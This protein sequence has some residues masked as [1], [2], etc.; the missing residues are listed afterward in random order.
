M[1]RKLQDNLSLLLS[2]RTFWGSKC[3]TKVYS[4]LTL[5]LFTARS[6]LSLTGTEGVWE[7][8]FL[9][10][11]SRYLSDTQV[12]TVLVFQK[13]I[14][15]WGEKKARYPIGLP[16]K[17][18]PL[19]SYT[20]KKW[21]NTYEL[22]WGKQNAL[23]HR[24]N[25][26]LTGKHAWGRQAGR[27]P[28]QRSRTQGQRRERANRQKDGQVLCHSHHRANTV[29]THGGLVSVWPSPK[30]QT[31]TEVLMKPAAGEKANKLWRARLRSSSW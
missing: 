15:Y 3:V 20:R 9:M 17:F 29:T 31:R 19:K 10:L 28:V 14:F 11:H 26:E 16:Q 2:P 30:E 25:K 27:R 21:F 23:Q 6:C 5:K 7:E 4:R 12:D 18:S 8:Q 1:E 22:N 13:T 24:T